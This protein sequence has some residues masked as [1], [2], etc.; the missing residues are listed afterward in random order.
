MSI[1]RLHRR[2]LNN[3][4]ISLV[5]LIVAM[6]LLMIVTVPI[7]YTFVYSARNNARARLRQQTTAAAQTVMENL[8]AYSVEKICQDFNDKTFPVSGVGSSGFDELIVS[9]ATV[10]AGVVSYS[11]G[12]IELKIS[13]MVYQRQTY[14]VDIKLTGHG[15]QASHIDFL[16]YESPTQENAASYAVSNAA[17]DSYALQQIM[18]IVAQRWNEREDAAGLLDPSATPAAHS[19]AEVDV[20]EVKI[21]ERELR[22]DIDQVGS[23]YVAKV[24]CVYTFNVNNYPYENAAT[25]VSGTFSIPEAGDPPESNMYRVDLSEGT[26][27]GVDFSR[28]IFRQNTE[29]EYLYLYY[30]PAYN[31]IPGGG[32]SDPGAPVKVEKDHIVIDNTT[33]TEIKCYIYKQKNLAI[34]DA[35]LRTSEGSYQTY[36]DLTNA[37]IYDDNLRT[38]LGGDTKM[39]TSSIHITPADKWYQGIGYAAV[40]TG[41]PNIAS[42]NYSPAIPTAMPTATVAENQQIMYDVEITL[43]DAGTDRELG[44]LKGTIVE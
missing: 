41:Y 32:L 3:V 11:G 21:V 26:G 1:R 31:Y 34:S 33:G 28:E 4:G 38:I 6:A 10:D 19:A 15:S 20:N 22:V 17:M 23:E 39:P 24:S 42:G 30:Y 14:D 18:G 2:K 13:G 12:E 36:I 29:L 8:K 43:F 37:C 5:E 35:R 40:E 25:G 27:G 44:T 7:L 9:G 16:K